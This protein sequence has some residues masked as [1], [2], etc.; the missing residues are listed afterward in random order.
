MGNIAGYGLYKLGGSGG[1]G[2]TGGIYGGSGTV[3]TA[4]IATLTDYL[5]FDGGYLI[6]DRAGA[7]DV[8]NQMRRG[9]SLKISDKLVSGGGARS[10]RDSG[11][12]DFYSISQNGLLLDRSASIGHFVAPT[13]TLDIVGDG[14]TDAT[15]SLLIRNSA[16]TESFRLTDASEATIKN[17]IAS[18]LNA[19]TLVNEASG[20]NHT[21]CGVKLQLTSNADTSYIAQYDSTSGGSNAPTM[22]IESPTGINYKANAVYRFGYHNFQTDNNVAF[23]IDRNGSSSILRSVIA[24]GGGTY[25][26]FQMA[27]TGG[28]Y[29]FIKTHASTG[30]KFIFGSE[31]GG[32][33]EYMRIAQDGEVL[34]GTATTDAS[35]LLNVSSTTKG[36]LQPVMTGAEVEAIASPA[37]GLQAYATNAGAGDVTAAGWWGYDGTNWVQGFSGGG[38]TLY[39]GDGSIATGVQRNVTLTGTGKLQ[40]VEVRNQGDFRVGTGDIGGRSA[41][42]WYQNGDVAIRQFYTG[43]FFAGANSDP[44]S[45]SYNAGVSYQFV[46]AQGKITFSKDIGIGGTYGANT[47]LKVI[48]NGSTNATYTLYVEN[49]SATASLRILDDG[50]VYNRGGGDAGFST[51]FGGEALLAQNSGSRFNTAFGTYAGKSLTTGIHNIAIGYNPLPIA[52]FDT[53]NIAIGNSSMLVASGGASQNT[54]IGDKTMASLTF[55]DRNVAVGANAGAS[56]TSGTDAVSVGYAADGAG[57][58][59][60]AIGS[61]A[62]TSI[63]KAIMLNSSGAVRDNTVTESFAVNVGSA[64]NVLFLGD[65]ADSYF[66]GTGGFGYGTT[67]PDA[68]ASVDITSTTKGFLPPRM[69]TVQMNAI[70][71]PATGLMVY[72]TT[73]NQWMG[74]NGTSWV[75]MG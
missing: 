70:S 63:T 59:S 35:A 30:G 57:T 60:I 32:S 73:T 58:Y 6:Y 15:T 67:T 1:G 22:W 5:R 51:A 72:D 54:A 65:T 61:Q 50:S 37:T 44:S 33:F 13:A 9:T 31:N 34:I 10:M 62:Q 29:N 19:L 53:Y 27:Y 20:G 28:D 21:D 39:S 41:W 38:T 2:G 16:A 45:G 47:R 75:I 3:P 68:S 74:Y 18:P 49:S 69:T 40:I 8:F 71:S 48:G 11:G 17:N 43:N 23:G 64:T 66:G 12:S 55:G 26:E 56:Q 46:S 7:S 36:F 4:T 52:T 42:S 14:A 24:G 25:S